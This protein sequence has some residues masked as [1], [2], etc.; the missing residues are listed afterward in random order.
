LRE[1]LDI[2]DD[3]DVHLNVVYFVDK[4]GIF[5]VKDISVLTENGTKKVGDLGDVLRCLGDG[6]LTVKT[7]DE[8]EL[9]ETNVRPVFEEP[10]CLIQRTI[11]ILN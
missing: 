3:E 8:R 6:V 1:Q 5:S 11:K 10:A 2:K 9:T 4:S 7:V